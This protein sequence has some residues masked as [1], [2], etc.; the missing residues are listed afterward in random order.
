M[1]ARM[2]MRILVAIA[3]AACTGRPPAATT[4]A[5]PAPQAARAID[6]GRA[7]R[8]AAFTYAGLV[9]HVRVVGA[10]EG[11][12]YKVETVEV[13]RGLALRT[14]TLWGVAQSLAPGSE[15]LVAADSDGSPSS[16]GAVAVVPAA[17]RAQLDAWIQPPTWARYLGVVEIVAL[18]PS[19]YDRFETANLRVVRS[20][21]GDLPQH[22][23]TLVPARSE[24]FAPWKVGPARYLMSSRWIKGSDV[25]VHDLVPLGTEAVAIAAQPARAP[26]DEVAEAWSVWRAPVVASTT[27]R[28]FEESSGCGG[29]HFWLELQQVVRGDVDPAALP[30]DDGRPFVFAGGG[31]CRHHAFGRD[32]R[33]LAAGEI[34]GEPSAL[35]DDTPANRR[36]V[37]R[38][39]AAAQPRFAALPVDDAAFA[40]TVE[41]R[42]ERAA[43]FEP[44]LTLRAIHG[45]R[46]G[47]VAAWTR[48]EVVRVHR[49]GAHAW[50]HLRSIPAQS[51]EAAHEWMFAGPDLPAWPAGSRWIG[52]SIGWRGAELGRLP[53]ALAGEHLFLPDAFLP[54]GIDLE[55]LL[56]V[57]GKLRE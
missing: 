35:M 10:E 53:S 51:G 9:A 57:T 50:M 1:F 38:W 18:A 49:V 22:L 54:D 15:W 7:W 44:A 30:D 12:S 21:R 34:G 42:H 39:S 19:A 27:A 31:H 3:L 52:Y 29:T 20:L 13:Y 41:P 33:Y 5:A 2:P 4:P 28:V 40:T 37:A 8:E 48:F 32:T 55:R 23:Y 16:V 11:R 36:R 56:H 43:L 14:F 47:R 46:H 25:L 24:L 6:P 45:G 17:E 26:L